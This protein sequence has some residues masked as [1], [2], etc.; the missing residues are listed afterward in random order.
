MDALLALRE[1][2]AQEPLD[3]ASWLVYSDWLLERGDARGE[4]IVIEHKLDTAR[5]SRDERHQLV[6]RRV[7]LYREH[8]QRWIAGLEVPRDAYPRWRHGFIAGLICSWN[9][10]NAAFLRRLRSHPTGRLLSLLDLA[11]TRMRDAE[12]AELA[13]QPLG[14]VTWLRLPDNQIGPAGAEAFARSL[15]PGLL[16]LE[17]ARN[18]LGPAGVSALLGAPGLCTLSSLDLSGTGLG[19]E[20]ERALAAAP[21]ALGSLRSLQLCSNKLDAVALADAELLEPLLALDLSRNAIGDEGAASLASCERLRGLRRLDL[22]SNQI[23]DTGAW[24]LVHAPALRSLTEL[25]LGDNPIDAD[26]LALR[27]AAS[28]RGCQLLGV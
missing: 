4:L 25:R 19:V 13:S 6:M 17:L 5:L 21:Q 23:G 18:A 20:G 22:S 8:E 26:S 12:V 14:T 9:P 1:G 7:A 27:H 2:L 10:A 3:W 28:E 11:Q 15:G 16:R 24:A